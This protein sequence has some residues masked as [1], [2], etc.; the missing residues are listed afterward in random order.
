MVVAR[1]S[2]HAAVAAAHAVEVILAD[3]FWQPETGRARALAGS[4][5]AAEAFQKVSRSLRLTYALERSVAE[6]LC[7]LRAGVPIK[8]R[9]A[10]PAYLIQLMRDEVDQATSPTAELPQDEIETDRPTS[11]SERAG[12]NAERLREYDR[13]DR[14]RAAGFQTTVNGLCAEIGA[15]VDWASWAI[16]TRPLDDQPVRPKPPGW[17]ETRPPP[18][19]RPGRA[20]IANPRDGSLS[21]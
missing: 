6:G 1:A 18:G 15:E 14:L 19:Y 7:D 21:P 8:A 2:A 9:E 12:A 4:K 13:P 5:D 11:V 20:P 10:A 16:N 17:S 3:D